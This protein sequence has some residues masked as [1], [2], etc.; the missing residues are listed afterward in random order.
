MRQPR[1]VAGHT[2]QYSETLTQEARSFAREDG[3]QFVDA[4]KII[5]AAYGL[6]F[7]LEHASETQEGGRTFCIADL[8]ITVPSETLADA[9]AN[10]PL[11]YGGNVFGRHR[12]AEDG[13]QC[14]V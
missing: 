1:R 13:R 5:A 4:D 6:A 9:E 10:S 3:R 12:A 14:R 7:S 11:L 2:R 8:N